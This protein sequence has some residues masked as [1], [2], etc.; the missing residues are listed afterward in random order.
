MW[1]LV[2]LA[3]GAGGRSA[4]AA[5]R[6]GGGRA[7]IAPPGGTAA[8]PV[9]PG[10]PPIRTG[11]CRQP[12]SLREARLG[13]RDPSCPRS[14]RRRR[15][16]VP[17]PD[18]RDDA[19]RVV[20]LGHQHAVPAQC[21]PVEHRGLH[22]ERL[23]HGRPGDLRDPDRR[24]RRPSRPAVLVHARGGDTARVDAPLPRHVAD[25]RPVHRLGARVDAARTRVHVLLGGDRGVARRRAARDRP[26][27]RSRIGLRPGADRGRRGDARRLGERRLHRAGDE[28]RASRT[29]FARRSS[30]SR[31]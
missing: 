26:P 17:R 18:P 21:R 25:P 6:F 15:T 29:S 19:R 10:G 28:P 24:R 3:G 8:Q 12:P 13:R 9:S 22:G 5:P 16:H 23:L 20:H 2:A 4:A 11:D 27:G 1:S 14:G 7:T 30:A 31:S